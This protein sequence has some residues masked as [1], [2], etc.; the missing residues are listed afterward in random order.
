[1][2][3]ELET[4]Q[5]KHYVAGGGDPFL[6]Y[7]VYGEIDSSAPLSRSTYR[8]DGIPDGIEVMS[9]GPG[10]H[11][12]VPGSFR[13]GYLWDEFV[14][15]DPR[16]AR[17][18]A[19]CEHCMILRGTPTDSTTLDYF[20]DTVGLVTYLID[21]GGCVVYDP[22][23]FRWWQPAEWKQKIFE[24]AG[25]VP[26][27]HTVILVSEEDDPSLKWFHTRGMRKFGRPDI[28]VHNVPAELEEGVIDLCN[29]LIEHQAFGHVV[30]DG[31][32][33]KMASLPSGGVVRHGG[34]LD[35][36]DFNNVHL[37]VSWTAASRK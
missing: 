12:D 17:A 4:W 36:P 27:H 8:S 33:I 23:M 34:D 6:F 5:R 25:P 15:D 2:T 22:L 19:Q 21:R 11:P 7:V 31:Q 37:D 20:R 28:S 29:R 3:S 14:A 16:L 1:V 18:V 13:E 9:Y 32:E 10:Q 26:R 30:P 24:P 35:D